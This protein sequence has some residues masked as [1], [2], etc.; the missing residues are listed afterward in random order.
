MAV[1]GGAVLAVKPDI[2]ESACAALAPARAPRVLSIVAGI[3]SE[4]L[5]AA[6]PPETSVI[7]AM[8]NT[9]V[10]VGAGVSVISGGLRAHAADL[11]W[12]EGLLSCGR[13]CDPVAR[14]AAACGDRRCRDPAPPTSI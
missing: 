8:P 3:P 11:D 14:A 7:R 1:D 12:A 5:E 13:H 9:P 10:L 2:A 4:R 6:L